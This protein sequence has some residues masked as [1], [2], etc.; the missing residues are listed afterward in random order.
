MPVQATRLWSA[1][2]G[3]APGQALRLSTTDAWEAVAHRVGEQLH[4]MLGLEVEV[5]VLRSEQKRAARRGLAVKQPR[6]WDV[7]LLEQDSQTVD[8]PT[9]ELHRAFVGRSEEFRAGPTDHEFE[10]LFTDLVAQTSQAKQILA[11]NR[12]DRYV[13][14]QSLALFFVAPQVLYAV[15]WDVNLVSYATSFE[16]ADTSVRTDHW[17]M[18]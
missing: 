14:Q 7:L 4:N 16:L 18:R 1:V 10:R 9:L 12:I 6:D 8:V 13:T 15:N 17:S 11:S 3:A 5:S 2:G